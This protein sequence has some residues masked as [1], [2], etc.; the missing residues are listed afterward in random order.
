MLGVAEF[1]A[2]E[3]LYRIQEQRSD[4]IWVTRKEWQT[5]YAKPLES[6]VNILRVKSWVEGLTAITLSK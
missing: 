3:I 5:Y 2:A 4:H 1:S 6:L